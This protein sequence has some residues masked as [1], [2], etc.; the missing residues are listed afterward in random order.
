VGVQRLHNADWGFESNCFVCEPRNPIG[1]RIPFEHDRDM[2]CVTAEF[3]LEDRFS[4]A[5]KF[6]HGGIVLAILDEA[7]AWATIAV[8][9]KFAVT[10]DTST[11]FDHPVY[12]ER[13]YRV[14]AF[15]DETSDAA[16]AT[17]AHVLDT[18]DRRCAE[19]RARFI[20]L[21]A[22]KAR[23]AIGDV[24]DVDARMLRDAPN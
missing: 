22:A 6:V 16:M 3:T 13:T 11:T 10:K 24:T 2:G 15:V 12:V 19:A 14:E 23:S 1:L 18:K 21:S 17:R 4:G 5:P 20:V 7:M 8:G 9:G